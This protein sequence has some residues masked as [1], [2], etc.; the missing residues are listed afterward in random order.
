MKQ[1]QCGNMY[2]KEG[3]GVHY[4]NNKGYQSTS[5]GSEE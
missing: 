1:P 2:N 5:K 3:G 4:S